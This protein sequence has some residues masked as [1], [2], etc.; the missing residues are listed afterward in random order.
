MAC[1]FQ[2]LPQRLRNLRSG[3]WFRD[4]QDPLRF[5]RTQ[6]R[7]SRLRRIADDDSGKVCVI[8]MVTHGVEQRLAHIIRSA[9]QDQRF[10][11]LRNN[12]FVDADVVTVCENFKARIAQRKGQQLGNLRRV[13]NKQDALQ[14][15]STS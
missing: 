3:K 10:G 2:Q 15:Y 1:L 4:Q 13:V 12:Q 9:I 8:G 14:A 5:S 11:L 6:A 7:Y